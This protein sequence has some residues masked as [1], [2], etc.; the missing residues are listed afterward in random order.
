MLFLQK[1]KV[2][3]IAPYEGMVHL[4]SKVSKQFERIEITIYTGNLDTG[5]EIAEQQ[6]HNN[7][8]VIISRGGTAKLIQKHIEVPVVEVSISA[9]DV[10]SAIKATENYAGKFVI[11]G[12]PNTTE[13][14]KMICDILQ[15]QIPIITFENSEDAFAKLEQLQQYEVSLVVSDMIGCMT[16]RKLGMNTILLSSGEES[17]RAAFMETLKLMDAA[18]YVHKQK[19]LFQKIIMDYM[20]D[21][22]IYKQN[23]QLWFSNFTEPKW[24]QVI[25][26]M[27][28]NYVDLFFEKQNCTIEKV[29]DEKIFSFSNRNYFHDN[30]QYVV[31]TIQKRPYL[32]V[33]NEALFEIYHKM[34]DSIFS[35]GYSSANYVGNLSNQ[36]LDYAKTSFPIM[37]IGEKGTGKQKAASLIYEN[38]AYENQPFYIIDCKHMTEK[39]FTTLLNHENSPLYTIHTTILLQN[40]D[41]LSE[42]QVMRFLEWK[43]QTHASQKIRFIFSVIED[44]DGSERKKEI[45]HMI[46][47]LFSCMVLRLPPLRERKEDIVNIATLYLN[48]I[49]IKLGK[50][51]IGFQTDAMQQIQQFFWEYN[52]DQLKRIIQELAVCTHTPYITKELTMEIL[53]KET[54]KPKKVIVENTL[55]L[56]QT[57]YEINYDIIQLVLEQEQNNKE[58]AAKHLGIS[59]STLWRMLKNHG[60]SE[61]NKKNT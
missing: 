36:I 11:A 37:L 50:Q 39:R 41:A 9:Y 43:K 27:A 42:M 19:N 1:I 61:V 21:I 6:A 32:L 38:S 18:R 22:L 47:N 53:S 7:Y 8:D 52:L 25:L 31:V 12:F 40:I 49:S 2:L 54:V 56:N 59:R 20:T 23:R 5:V 17:V 35:Y 55:N 10:L 34:D 30:E 28:E 15:Y 57:L 51:I 44:P 4:L 46:V 24:K 26:D 58:K 14:A 48:Q 16:A 60:N 29:V 13:Y 3:A 33:N 45:Y